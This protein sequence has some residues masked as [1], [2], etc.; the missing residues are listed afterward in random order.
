MDIARVRVE[1][2]QICIQ[3]LSH[4]TDCRVRNA[5]AGWMTE[6]LAIL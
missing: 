4:A 1:K 5:K 2:D 3:T 6:G